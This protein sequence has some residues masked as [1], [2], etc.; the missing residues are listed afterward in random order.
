M[1][2]PFTPDLKKLKNM[3][4]IGDERTLKTYLKYLEDAGIIL[5]IS[6][7]GKR[8]KELEKPEKIYLNNPNLIYA[9]SGH[10][11]SNIGNLRETFF[12]NMLSVYHRVTIP[13][14]GDFLVDEK[15]IFEVRG[16]NKDFTSDQES[17]GF[18]FINR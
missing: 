10:V 17:E 5:T 8:L 7:S 4:D 14:R 1:S 16:N 12:L 2:V 15:Y 11:P 9:T 3:L 18:L 6:R 13:E